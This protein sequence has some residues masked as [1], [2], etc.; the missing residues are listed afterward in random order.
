MDYKE[1]K[2][3]KIVSDILEILINNDLNDPLTIDSLNEE[4]NNFLQI[5]NW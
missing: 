5:I 2:L 1:S 3:L 4:A